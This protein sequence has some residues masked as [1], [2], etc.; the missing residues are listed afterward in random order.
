MKNVK[1][2]TLMFSVILL[3]ASFAKAGYI[4]DGTYEPVSISGWTRPLADGA[5]NSAYTQNGDGT[6]TIITAA[7]DRSRLYRNG[8]D[9]NHIDTGQTVVEYRAKLDSMTTGATYGGAVGLGSGSRYWILYF[10][11]IGVKEHSGNTISVNT[12]VMQNYKAVISADGLSLDFYVNGVLKQT[13][14][15]MN[16][17]SNRLDMGDWSG[18]VGGSTTWDYVQWT[19]NVPEPATMILLGSGFVFIRKYFAR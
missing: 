6:G 12:S 3:S 8:S 11:N 7:A 10:N 19:H 14:S 2:I 5:P 1:L 18:S 17:T 13:W 15:G 4:W 16:S 9:W